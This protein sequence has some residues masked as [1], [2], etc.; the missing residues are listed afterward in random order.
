MQTALPKLKD[1]GHLSAHGWYY[2]ARPED[3]ENA[4]PA[5]RVTMEEFLHHA[6]LQ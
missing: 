2:T 4:Q 6:G 5:F 3:L 1:A